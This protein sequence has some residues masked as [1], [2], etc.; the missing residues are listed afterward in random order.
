MNATSLGMRS[1]RSKLEQELAA[2][3]EGLRSEENSFFLLQGLQQLHRGKLQLGGWRDLHLLVRCDTHTHE[4]TENTHTAYTLSVR[5]YSHCVTCTRPAH[6]RVLP[7]SKR[8]GGS[9]GG[10]AEQTR[11]QAEGARRGDRGRSERVAQRRSTK[12]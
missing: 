1:E 12:Q 5:T 7:F 11:R 8:G 6:T 3:E 2:D 9:K 10:G 4:H